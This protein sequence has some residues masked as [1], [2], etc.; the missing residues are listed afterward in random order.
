MVVLDPLAA[1][2]WTLWPPTPVTLASLSMESAAAPGLV[3][4]MEC[5][6]GLLQFVSVS[7]WTLYCLFVECI[8]SHTANCSDLL[9][10]INGMIMYTAGSPGNRPFLT[11][12]VHSCNTGYTLIGGTTR[13]CIGGRWDG[14]AP[15]CQSEYF[16]NSCTVCE[17]TCT[18]THY[19]N[20]ISGCMWSKCSYVKDLTPYTCTE[21]IDPP[22][23]TCSD[24]SSLTNGMI[25]YS[26]G[27]PGNRP[28]LASAT[29]TCNTGYTLTGG[30]TTRVCA[31]GGIWS[32][33]PSTCQGE[34]HSLFN[35]CLWRGIFLSHV[36]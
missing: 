17:H 5:G 25:M 10:L 4:V 9:P 15:T 18:Q 33:S 34:F 16:Y 8:V 6:V 36:T 35:M 12:A 13:F 7:K 30:E 32:G 31:S 29:Y 28:F 27:S 21:D 26:A 14:S 23:T 3:G 19:V 11:N 20:Q 24:L 1:D 22:P 2:Q